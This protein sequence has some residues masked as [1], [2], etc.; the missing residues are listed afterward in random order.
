V[1][2]DLKEGEFLRLPRIK[3]RKE[4]REEGKKRRKLEIMLTKIA[5]VGFPQQRSTKHPRTL[6]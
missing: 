5:E 4:G 2:D 1:R 3:G 6:I